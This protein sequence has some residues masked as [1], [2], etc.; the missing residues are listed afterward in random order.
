[1]FQ[2]WSL[3]IRELARCSNLRLKAGWPGHEGRRFAFDERATPPSS[4]EL[5]DLWRPYVLTCVEAFGAERCLF[6][7]NFPVDKGMFSYGVLWNAFK[8]LTQGWDKDDRGSAV[9]RHGQGY[10]PPIIK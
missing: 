7:S 2:T 8:R 10:L 3:A 9:Q 6:E 5:A 1:M 4:A